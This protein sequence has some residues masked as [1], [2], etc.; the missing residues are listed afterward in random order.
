MA[1]LVGLGDGRTVDALKKDER[2]IPASLSMLPFVF[3]ALLARDANCKDYILENIRK[4]YG[5][6]LEAGATSFWETIDGES[7]FGGAGSL[8]H[9]WS[10]IPI[11]YYHIFD[12]L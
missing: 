1:L 6:M 9:G 10:A 3:D 8:C 11:Q 7:A 2:L 4:T 5:Q 12:M